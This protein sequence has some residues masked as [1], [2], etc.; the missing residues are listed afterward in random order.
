MYFRKQSFIKYIFCKY[1][2]LVCDL[3]IY[4]LG[5]ISCRAE[6]FNFG[7]IRL[8][9]S[10]FHW[11]MPLVLYLKALAMARLSRFFP[12]LSS[13]SFIVFYLGLWCILIHFKLIFL[14]GV[15]SVPRFIFLP[16]DFCLF[17]YP[18]LIRPCSTVLP[19]LL[20]QRLVD[21]IYMSLFWGSLFC[22]TDLF[23]S[24]F[25]TLYGC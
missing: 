8:I 5:S 23:V 14:K 13:R 25:T 9:N 15:R 24:S 21:H 19:L 4:S 12:I 22:C 6:I 17:Q 18:L 11:I 16:V 1:F 7:E 10:F 3:S 20:C 2:L